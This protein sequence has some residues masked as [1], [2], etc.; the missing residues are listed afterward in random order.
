M[1][2]G[3][4]NRCDNLDVSKPFRASP[5]SQLIFAPPDEISKL[6]VVGVVVV[7]HPVKQ[8]RGNLHQSVVGRLL[9]LAAGVAVVQVI[10]LVCYL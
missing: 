1:S 10:H 6:L 5:G 2:W 4:Q 7:L 9:L 3:H 8:R